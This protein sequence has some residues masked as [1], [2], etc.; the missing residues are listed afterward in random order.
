[1]A[2]F[3]LGLTAPDAV[4]LTDLDGVLEARSSHAALL[5]DRLGSQL[6]LTLLVTALV[7]RGREEH[8]RLRTSTCCLVLPLAVLNRSQF[9][10]PVTSPSRNLAAV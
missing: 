5:A 3:R 4:L 7:M 9:D 6:S 1:M 10:P 8:R 2:T